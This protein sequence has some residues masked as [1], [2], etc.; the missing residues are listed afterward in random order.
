MRSVLE[1]DVLERDVD[2]AAIAAGLRLIYRCIVT[3]ISLAIIY[4]ALEVLGQGEPNPTARAL[5]IG[6]GVLALALAAAVWSRHAVA[7]YV[8]VCAIPLLA[9]LYL[10]ELRQRVPIDEYV[11]QH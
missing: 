11:E 3:A 7:M 10:F 9:A 6:V 8:Q 5:L 2:M 1:R 4:A